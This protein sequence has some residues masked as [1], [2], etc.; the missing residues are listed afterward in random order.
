[1]YSRDKLSLIIYSYSYFSTF[2]LTYK[3][4]AYKVWESELKLKH[5]Y[6]NTFTQSH[7]ISYA[8]NI[9]EAINI[10]CTRFHNNELHQAGISLKTDVYNIVA[11]GS[12]DTT[13]IDDTIWRCRFI[14]IYNAIVC[15]IHIHIWSILTHQIWLIVWKWMEIVTR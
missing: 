12:C 13:R 15:G 1:M 6:I 2:Q 14:L 9:M 5:D 3:I 11:M 10:H 7:I 8:E 4:E